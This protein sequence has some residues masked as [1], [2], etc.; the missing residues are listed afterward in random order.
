VTWEGIDVAFFPKTP[1]TL[2]D[3]VV[4][5]GMRRF[6]HLA[7]LNTGLSSPITDFNPL[8]YNSM[9]LE[10]TDFATG[11]LPMVVITNSVFDLRLAAN[12]H[13]D[14]PPVVSVQGTS[15]GNIWVGEVSFVNSDSLESGVGVSIALN[16]TA[17]S[18]EAN[19]IQP[20]VSVGTLGITNE[21]AYRQF[22]TQIYTGA[23]SPILSAL[24][25]MVQIDRDAGAIEVRLPSI[26]ADGVTRGQSVIVKAVTASVVGA[27]S[28][29]SDGA[30][31]IDGAASYAF[32]ATA[33]HAVTFVSDGVS[34][35][36]IVAAY[37]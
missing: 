37:P 7:I 24:Q 16:V 28:V 27:V 34:N 29:V 12:S 18:G 3:G 17:S 30:D 19:A 21:T 6:R 8:I 32:P 13:L 11:G 1:V 20:A 33:R 26:P 14:G 22:P 23:S 35:W 31:T 10:A 36:N 25:E 15:S 9:F 5:T 4:L 2:A